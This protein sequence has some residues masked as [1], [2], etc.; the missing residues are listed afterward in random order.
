[1]SALDV[2]GRY[3]AALAAGDLATLAGVLAPDVVWH[4]PGGNPLSGDHTGREAVMAHLGSFMVVSAGTFR[5]VPDQVV[6]SG[7]LVVMTVTFAAEREGRAPLAQHGVDV[8]RVVGEEIAEV[9]L[10]SE[11]QAAEDAFWG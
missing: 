8:F 4:Q 6:P 1:M 3:G 7:D 9:W 2:V 10:I 5:L 11:D